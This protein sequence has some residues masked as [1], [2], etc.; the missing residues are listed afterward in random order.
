MIPNG[1]DELVHENVVEDPLL[2]PVSDDND[3][4]PVR[5]LPRFDSDTRSE[6]ETKESTLQLLLER[7]GLSPRRTESDYLNPATEINVKLADLGNACWTHHHFTE[8]IQT[9]QYRSLEVLIGAGYGDYL[10]EPHSGDTYSRDE[11]HL[12]HI[13]ELLGY[14]CPKVYRKGAHWREFFDNHGHLLHICHLKPWSLVEVLTQKYDWPIESAGQFASF[15]IPMLE[16][17]QNERATARECLQH[18][19][20]KP[21]GGKPLHNME[22][23]QK[24][25]V[26]RKKEAHCQP[27]VLYRP[28]VVNDDEGSCELDNE[29]GNEESE[30]CFYEM[31]AVLGEESQKAISGNGGEDR[32]L[33]ECFVEVKRSHEQR[34]LEMAVLARVMQNVGVCN[35]L[36]S[37]YIT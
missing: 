15:L 4:E 1:Q 3:Q 22:K 17:D 6:S 31:N 28:S 29:S 14:I 21:N 33:E 26:L 13:I 24:P 37:V 16:F 32:F 18:D 8:D 20:L 9:R 19:W 34:G 25:P 11:D 5:F 35:I 2:I 27:S 23:K 36:V 30:E 7:D 10:F 12:A